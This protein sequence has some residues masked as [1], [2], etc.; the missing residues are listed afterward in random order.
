MNQSSSFTPHEF[1]VYKLD[2]IL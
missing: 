1:N 2:Y